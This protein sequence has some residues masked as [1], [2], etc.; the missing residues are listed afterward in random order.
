MM[1]FA[2]AH[3]IVTLIIVLSFFTLV[4]RLIPWSR[5]SPGQDSEG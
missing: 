2:S 4:G 5:R 1:E 3:P